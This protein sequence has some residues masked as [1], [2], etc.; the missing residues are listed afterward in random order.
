MRTIELE[1]QF[2][3][4]LRY[5]VDTTG[6]KP[7]SVKLEVVEEI[8]EELDCRVPDPVIA[9]FAAGFGDFYGSGSAK[10]IRAV[11]KLTASFRDAVAKGGGKPRYNPD[12]WIIFENDNGNYL[13]F[14]ADA[15]RDQQTI[16]FFDHEGAFADAPVPMALTERLYEF[17]RGAGGDDRQDSIKELDPFEVKLIS[18]KPKPPETGLDEDLFVEH[19]KF[20]RGQV[21]SIDT[22]SKHEKW[23]V[24]FDSGEK[25]LLLARFLDVVEERSE[26]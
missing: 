12:G 26:R 5:A 13:G 10:R 19:P 14:P 16:H 18:P 3:Q 7:I 6:A 24:D 25:K 22:T 15:S 23:E 4:I 1:K 8:E 21:M 9:Y 17:I 20:G 11:M 2:A